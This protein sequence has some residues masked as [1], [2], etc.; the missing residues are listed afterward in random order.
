[1]KRTEQVPLEKPEIISPVFNLNKARTTQKLDTGFYDGAPFPYPHTLFIVSTNRKWTT[2]DLVAQGEEATF[3]E[4]N[5][6]YEYKIFSILSIAGAWTGAILAGKHDSHGHSG[7]KF[8][9]NVVVVE[10]SYQM[11]EVLSFCDLERA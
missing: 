2:S 9:M 1:M 4:E 5:N 7:T 3:P 8:R 6:N 10:M 11:L